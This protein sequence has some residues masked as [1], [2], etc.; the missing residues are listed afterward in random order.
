MKYFMIEGT[1]TN[2]NLMTDAIMKEHMAYSQ[3]A[4]EQGLIFM[5]S[6]KS[7]MSGGLSLMQADS[8]EQIENYLANEPFKVHGIQNYKITEFDFHYFNPSVVNN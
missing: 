8:I 6:L 1:L 3:Q 2:P 7:D 4:M 5:S